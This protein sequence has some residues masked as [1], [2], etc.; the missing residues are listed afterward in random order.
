VT[1]TLFT[2][3]QPTWL[4]LAVTLWG[5]QATGQQL[6]KRRVIFACLPC[7]DHNLQKRSVLVIVNGHIWCQIPSYDTYI[8]GK[9]KHKNLSG[10][11]TLPPWCD[12]SAAHRQWPNFKT[13]VRCMKHKNLSGWIT[14]AM[15]RPK[16][17]AP[18]VTQF[19]DLGS[20]YEIRS[21]EWSKYHIKHAFCPPHKAPNEHGNESH[22]LRTKR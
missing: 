1:R 12:P 16:C 6:S 9:R 2:Q 4:F 17:S 15:M 5:E 3:F 18:A 10:W 20:M 19:Q 14:P 21:T 13:W 22:G 7:K 11:I 8:Q